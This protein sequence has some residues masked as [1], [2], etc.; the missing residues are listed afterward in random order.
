MTLSRR[1]ILE[2]AA[3]AALL[4]AGTSLARAQAFPTRPIRIVIGYPAGGSTDLLARIVGQYLSERLGQTFVIENKPGAGTNL[5]AQTVVAAPP[6]GY[7]L[8]FA[9]ST[10]AIN[11]TL[12]DSLP[13]NFPARYRADRRPRRIAAGAGRQHV[14]AG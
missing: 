3:A 11:A 1:R 14:V 2:L 6:D 4:P 13:Y 12:Y 5:A 9:A 10:Y 7:T 8:L